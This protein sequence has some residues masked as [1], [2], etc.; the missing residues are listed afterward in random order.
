[1]N[2]T[3]YLLH[4]EPPLGH[5]RHYLG[6][7][8]DHEQ[9]FLE[10]CRGAGSPL[11]RAAV[12]AGCEVVTARTWHGVDRHFER[13]LK[14]RKETPRLCPICVQAGLTGGRG[15]LAADTQSRGVA[16]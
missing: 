15:L 1:M 8:K 2:G 6:W 3:V 16:A 13:R 9:R 7:A 4:F 5:A 12:A 10:H 14:N 11:V